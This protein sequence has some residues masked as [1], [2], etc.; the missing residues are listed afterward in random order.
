MATRAQLDAALDQEKQDITDAIARH[1]QSL[2]DALA[3]QQAALDA[4]QAKLDAQEDFSAELATLQ[5]THEQLQSLAATPIQ[6]ITDP[7]TLGQAGQNSGAAGTVVMGAAGNAA[8][9]AGP[10]GTDAPHTEDNPGAGTATATTLGGSGVANQPAEEEPAT[11]KEVGVD[12]ATQSKTDLRTQAD[13]RG[14]TV[15]ASA[16]KQDLVDALEADD[17]AKAASGAGAGGS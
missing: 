14:L 4:L 9:A 8:A 7:S 10:G 5:T 13:S 6:Q 12:Y 17:A 1:E 11:D 2:K 15:P 16:T 3:A